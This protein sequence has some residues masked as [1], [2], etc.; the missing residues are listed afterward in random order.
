L[1]PSYLYSFVI[2]ED[3]SFGNRTFSAAFVQQV[4]VPE[5]ATLALLAPFAFGFAAMRRRRN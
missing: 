2:P 5:P 1:I 4:R 3:E